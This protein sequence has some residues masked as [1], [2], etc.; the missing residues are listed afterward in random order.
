MFKG[1]LFLLLSAMS[2]GKEITLDRSHCSIDQLFR[3]LTDLAH[4]LPKKY[5][6]VQS[7]QRAAAIEKP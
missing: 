3:E 5:A 6:A 2:V 1:K 7:E 4:H